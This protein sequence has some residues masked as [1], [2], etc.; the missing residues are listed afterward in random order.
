MEEVQCDARKLC[1]LQHDEWLLF[2]IIWFVVTIFLV[3]LEPIVGRISA[4][5]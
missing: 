4:Y 1:L 5:L 2:S 3:L